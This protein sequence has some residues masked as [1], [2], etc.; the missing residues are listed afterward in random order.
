MRPG[1][2][3]EG[4]RGVVFAGRPPRQRVDLTGAGTSRFRFFVASRGAGPAGQRLDRVNI[5]GGGMT[6]AGT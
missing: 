4:V 3:V 2:S 6:L 5:P 1:V